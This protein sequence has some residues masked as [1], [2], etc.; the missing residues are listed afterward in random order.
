MQG[1]DDDENISD[2]GP[3]SAA[4][5]IESPHDIILRR[6]MRKRRAAW[7]RRSP[8]TTP[9]NRKLRRRIHGALEQDQ[10]Q[11]QEQHEA[12]VKD[13]EV[14]EAAP[15]QEELLNEVLLSLENPTTPPPQRVRVLPGPPTVRELYESKLE[16]RCLF[17]PLMPITPDFW[18][19][20]YGDVESG[21]LESTVSFKYLYLKKAFICLRPNLIMFYC[22]QH[23][24]GWS[25]MLMTWRRMEME[26]LS[27]PDRRWTI[28]P[29]DFIGV[30]GNFKP[31]K[32]T[33]GAISEL[34]TKENINWEENYGFANGTRYPY[35][36]WWHCDV[37]SK[38]KV[39]YFRRH[40]Y[41]TYVL[42]V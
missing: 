14:H 5:D 30:I 18:G 34:I 3:S 13:Q 10:V 26:R 20:L 35:P 15:T 36:A 23:I 29:L 19:R 8:F 22:L 6:G 11:V 40:F 32:K 38:I 41:C 4:A 25:Y 12:S 42:Y 27:Q 1:H 9:G 7:V 24:D 17:Y 28:M 16:V 21:Y 39:C 2:P 31:V 37:V 33:M